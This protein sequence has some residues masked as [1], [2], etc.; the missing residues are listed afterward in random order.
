ML[1]GCEADQQAGAA[2]W[3]LITRW[4]QAAHA[5]GKVVGALRPANL[6]LQPGQ[7]SLAIHFQPQPPSAAAEAEL[8]LYGSPEELLR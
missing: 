8:Q 7:P 6:F 3:M 4:V 5:E 1:T 2:P